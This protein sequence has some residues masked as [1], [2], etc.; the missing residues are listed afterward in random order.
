MTKPWS[1][2]TAREIFRNRFVRLYAVRAEFEAGTKEYFVTDK[3]TRVGVLIVQDDKVL[4]VRQYRFLINDHSWEI[5]GGGLDAPETPEQ[6]AKRECWEEAR[7]RCHSIE[8]LFDYRLGLDTTDC[9]VLLYRATSITEAPDVPAGGE[10]D[11]REWVPLDEC[12]ERVRCRQITDLMTIV[13]ILYATHPR[14]G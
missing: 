10:T 6:A 7:V 3:G 5:P 12:L 1:L 2:S 8:P 4:L 13:A 9:R 14:A 11:A